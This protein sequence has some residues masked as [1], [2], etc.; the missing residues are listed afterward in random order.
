VTHT[1]KRGWFEKERAKKR[2]L[3]RD[4]YFYIRALSIFGR[5]D[6]TRRIVRHPIKY[7]G[8]H[9]HL[10]Q[11]GYSQLT[12]DHLS[13]GWYSEI[14]VCTHLCSKMLFPPLFV[15]ALFK[16]HK[17]MDFHLGVLRGT[18]CICIQLPF[19]MRNNMTLNISTASLMVL[20]ADCAV[21]H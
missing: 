18:Q 4:L 15:P 14:Y 12:M 10:H 9:G 19:Q 11:S 2:R 16:S 8:G 3:R 21:G 6:E 1:T 7:L 13:A 17:I 20:C 5:C